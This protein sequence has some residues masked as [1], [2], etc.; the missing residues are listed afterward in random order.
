[1]RSR[2]K[3][4]Q[5]AKTKL[6]AGGPVTSADVLEVL[7]LWRFH[8][9]KCRTNV[10]REGQQWVFSDTFLGPRCSDSPLFPH[11]RVLWEPASNNSPG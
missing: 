3:A 1:M 6:A 7:S 4:E 8:K 2:R 9:N 5:L 11:I 10:M